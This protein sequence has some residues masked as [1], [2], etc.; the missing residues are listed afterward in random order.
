MSQPVCIQLSHL[1]EAKWYDFH[2]DDKIS[3][4]IQF[5]AMENDLDESNYALLVVDKDG[6][7]QWMREEYPLSFYL[8]ASVTYEWRKRHRPVKV[9][10]PDKTYRTQLVDDTLKV[11]ALTAYIGQQFGFNGCAEEQSL[12]P[13]RTDV[14][15]KD[16]TL[17]EQG[18]YGL[19]HCGL[20]KLASGSG[21]GLY[22]QLAYMCG[23][24][25]KKG[26][27]LSGKSKK[28]YRLKKN[29]F[30]A[31][32]DSKCTQELATALVKDLGMVKAGNSSEEELSSKYEALAFTVEL[33]DSKPS[34]FIASTTKERDEWVNSLLNSKATFKPQKMFFA[35]V[36]PQKERVASYRRSDQVDVAAAEEMEM[37][38]AATAA[39]EDAK[40]IELEKQKKARRKSY[41]I[42]KG[43]PLGAS[44]NMKKP[45]AKSG[46][47]VAHLKKD[48]MR[49]FQSVD[50]SQVRGV[51]SGKKKRLSGSFVFEEQ[52]LANAS[53]SGDL[54][55][56]QEVIRE[57][58]EKIR[59]PTKHKIKIK[60]KNSIPGGD[61]V[62]PRG[63]LVSPRGDGPPAGPP[64][65]PGGPPAGAPPTPGGP[66]TPG[67]EK[68]TPSTGTSSTP[69]E[70]P[71]EEPTKEVVGTGGTGEGE[72]VMEAEKVTP[73]ATDSVAKKAGVKPRL[74]KTK[75]KRKRKGKAGNA[76]VFPVMITVEEFVTVSRSP[77]GSSLPQCSS[78][79]LRISSTTIYAPMPLCIIYSSELE[80]DASD[81]AA[82]A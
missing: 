11:E 2:P 7:G 40:R 15:V 53:E 3:Y 35:P 82:A 71:V 17:R 52:A 57:E 74:K 77:T 14:L 51:I 13:D 20:V 49:S 36:G 63:V 79:V 12:D 39:L 65:T 31:Y 9:I 69:G 64:P 30:A 32:K 38:K 70:V 41:A 54:P 59:G 68:S 10:M 44:G 61:F 45:A 60:K 1:K 48:S 47:A 24:L 66:K 62:S 16:M 34:V 50:S 46:G 5:I 18:Y 21:H 42:N 76:S 80:E 37:L 26:G 33:P 4:M 27:K 67:E 55:V 8:D 78:T 23:K 22:V 29:R 19:L 43:R 72:A 81:D 58:K 75:G 56:A 6:A 25:T 73:A 28:V